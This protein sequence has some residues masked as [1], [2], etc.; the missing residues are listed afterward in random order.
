[1]SDNIS[2]TINGEK[3]DFNVTADSYEKLI[4]ELQPNSKVTP[5]HNFLMR[6]VTPETKEM[7]VPFMSNP[8]NVTEICGKVMEEYSPKLKITLGE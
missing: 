7:L 4:D 5:M 8:G 2:L 3:I 6:T 1:M